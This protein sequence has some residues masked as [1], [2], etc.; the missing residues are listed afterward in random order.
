MVNFLR[1]LEASLG[2]VL[3]PNVLL[4]G[5]QQLNVALVPTS[6]NIGNRGLTNFFEWSK[7]FDSLLFS[8]FLAAGNFGN[9]LHISILISIFQY[10]RQHCL[11]GCIM[12]HDVSFWRAGNCGK[13]IFY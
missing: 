2:N 10:L 8:L 9:L 4:V 12:L 6:H 1:G 11:V 7:T 13:G 3:P 5:A